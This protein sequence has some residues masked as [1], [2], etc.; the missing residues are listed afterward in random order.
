MIKRDNVPKPWFLRKLHI[1]MWKSCNKLIWGSVVFL[2]LTSIFDFLLLNKQSFELVVLNISCVILILISRSF[3][4]KVQKDPTL[5]LHLVQ[6]SLN[7]LLLYSISKSN[8]TGQILYLVL[9]AISFFSFNII[10]CW[11]V[12]D[13]I[14]QFVAFVVLVLIFN[15]YRLINLENLLLNGGYATFSLCLVSIVIPS[16]KTLSLKDEINEEYEKSEKITGFIHANENLKKEIKKINSKLELIEN[17]TKI[18]QHDLKNHLSSIDSLI[19]LIELE[20]RYDPKTGDYDYLKLIKKSLQN[21]EEKNENFFKNFNKNSALI[22][23]IEKTELNFHNIINKHVYNFIE[24][25]S[26]QNI[27]FEIELKASTFSVYAEKKILNT[28]IY[29]LIKYTIDFSNNNDTIKISTRNEYDSIILE[30]V[31]RST[32]MSMIDMESYFKNISSHNLEDIK[33]NEGLGLSIAKRNIELMDG[34]LRYSASKSLGFEFLVEF[35]VNY[36]YNQ[37]ESKSV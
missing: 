29:N 6:L 31:N 14:M 20:D 16:I 34:H 19:D 3:L 36:S 18:Y 35:Q 2:V 32:G 24:T 28:A 22:D 10:A 30:I 37:T 4:G 13:S 33:K 8:I 9:L 23:K 11:K 25:A 5:L 17:K 21:A 27:H 7:F 12:R 15:H 1:K 26:S